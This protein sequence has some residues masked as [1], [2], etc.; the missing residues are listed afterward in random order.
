MRVACALLIF[1]CMGVP[2]CAAEDKG[3][4]GPILRQR[5]QID[6]IVARV[7]RPPQSLE[8][9]VCRIVLL[10]DRKDHGA[11]EHD[12]PLWQKRWALLF[13]GRE[14]SSE[15]QANLYGPPAGK[16]EVAT[17]H[18]GVQI[19]TAWSWPTDGMFEQADVIVAFCYV[20]WD[21]ARL[22]QMEAYLERGGGLVLIHS[23]TWTR[24]EPSA[25]VANLTGVGGFKYWRHGEIELEV[26]APNHPI[27]LGL[28][29]RIRLMDEPY[30]PPT[31][32]LD[33]DRVRV[34]AGCRESVAPKS[35]KQEFCP[36]FW[37]YE[38]GAG[39]VYGCVPGHYTWTF[40]DPLFRIL[41]LRG[42]AWA[43]GEWPYRFDAL[44]NRGVLWADRANRG[45]GT[46]KE[47][48]TPHEGHR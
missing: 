2:T 44:V 22:K 28:P 45:A 17:P 23:A 39:R 3:R 4:P 12:Y 27:C 41:L 47:G 18:T 13:G 37:T 9:R 7:P 36:L 29:P 33:P 21:P 8:D 32:A 42:I 24:P 1:V 6:A 40:D 43:A 5:E 26:V 30:W 31:P 19:Q 16:Y 35:E 48:T 20:Q 38:F 46:L 10:A 25:N 15:S 11:N 34:L 14:V